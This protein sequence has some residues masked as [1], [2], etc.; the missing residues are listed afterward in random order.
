MHGGGVGLPPDLGG[1]VG[2]PFDLGGG[3]GVGLPLDLGGGG[4]GIGLPLDLGGG[5][6]I[7]TGEDGALAVWDFSLEALKPGN[8]LSEYA[9]MIR[10]SF[11]SKVHASP[12]G[13]LKT[14]LAIV[15]YLSL[16]NRM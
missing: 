16:N 14:D 4:G 6:A 12:N 3:G 13:N 5:I 7:E 11:P 8:D 10:D 9:R 2:L 15:Y 1:G